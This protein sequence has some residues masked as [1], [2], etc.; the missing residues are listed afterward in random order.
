MNYN[1]DDDERERKRRR[2]ELHCI[3]V[4]KPNFLRR[5]AI[6]FL[7]IESDGQSVF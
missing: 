4:I 3:I 5:T 7:Y 6:I 2:V 1:D